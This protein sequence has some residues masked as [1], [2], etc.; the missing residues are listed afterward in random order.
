[1]QKLEFKSGQKFL[2]IHDTKH[3]NQLFYTLSKK[4]KKRNFHFIEAN[5][6]CKTKQQQKTQQDDINQRFTKI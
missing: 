1:M 2:Q 5:S 4:R 6:S 3:I